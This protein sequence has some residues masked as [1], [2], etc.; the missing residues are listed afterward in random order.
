MERQ[1]G[2]HGDTLSEREGV[3]MKKTPV[4]YVYGI[5]DT[6]KTRLV[7]RLLLMLIQKGKRAGTVKMSKSEQLD[8]DVRG[9]DTHRHIKAGSMITAASSR[10]NAAVFIPKPMNVHLLIE[11]MSI[12]GDLDVVI[13]E[14]MGDDVPD[15]APKVAVGEVKGRVPGT[16]MELPDAEGE[17]GGLYH[18]VDRIMSKTETMGEEDQVV[19]RVGGID[20]TMKPF[21]RDYLE[22]TIRGAV[23]S[24]HHTDEPGATIEI[25]IPER[26]GP[27]EAVEHPRS[28]DID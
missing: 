16:I 13:V 3:S 26:K 20:I 2:A 1:L 19:L 8:F 5:S 12:T 22:G 9:K 10:S 7:E 6:G 18:L 17:L 28:L 15:T 4:I 11:M 21:V 23:G 24:L 25:S 27:E 14:G